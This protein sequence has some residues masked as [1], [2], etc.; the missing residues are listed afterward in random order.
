MWLVLYA[1][2]VYFGSDSQDGLF[3]R[4]YEF[5]PRLLSDPGQGWQPEYGLQLRL[6][7]CEEECGRVLLL[8]PAALRHLADYEE[9]ALNY[10]GSEYRAACLAAWSKRAVPY[11]HETPQAWRELAQACETLETKQR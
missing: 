9:W 11:P 5:S 7:A 10:L 1:F 8:L 4:R 2:G 6:P 3:L